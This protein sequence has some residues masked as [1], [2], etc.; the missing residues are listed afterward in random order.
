[1]VTLADLVKDNTKPI[2]KE[3]VKGVGK[4]VT[5]RY[6]IIGRK[7]DGTVI[8]YRNLSAVK[9][10][11]TRKELRTQGCHAVDKIEVYS[12]IKRADGDNTVLTFTEKQYVPALVGRIPNPVTASENKIFDDR[13]K[14]RNANDNRRAKEN[15]AVMNKRGPE[16]IIYD[17]MSGK[18]IFAG[19]EGQAVFF[20]VNNKIAIVNVVIYMNNKTYAEAVK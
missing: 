7:L 6:D 5:R 17:K 2:P 16:A 9:A 18:A 20:L 11:R 10:N 15:K 19:T 13:A 12:T 14:M 1:M 8:E 3:P 4:I